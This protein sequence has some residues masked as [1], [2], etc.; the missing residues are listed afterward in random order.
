MNDMGKISYYLRKNPLPTMEGTQYMARIDQNK[1]LRQNDIIRLMLGK[2]TT[3]TRQDIIVVLDLLKETVKE[4]ILMGN[5]V[6]MELFKARLGIKGVFDSTTDEFDQ[7]R[8]QPCLNF[9]ATGEFRKDLLN[10]A[11]FEKTRRLFRKPVIEQLY[12]YETRA[13]GTEFAAG[14]VIGLIGSWLRP[15]KGDP[16]VFL[17]LEGEDDLIPVEKIMGVTDQR[18]MCRLP[19]GLDAGSYRILI[20]SGEGDEELKSPYG[21]V[22]TLT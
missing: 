18:V 14:S 21:E 8:H 12:N 22:I 20:I 2:N 15:E 11:V 9:S 13:M 4:Q 6:I 1:T 3:V 19:A 16:R 7:A 10:S 5:P 17:R